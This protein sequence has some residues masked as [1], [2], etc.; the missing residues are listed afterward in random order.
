M[1]TPVDIKLTEYDGQYD[2]SWTKDGDFEMT[3]TLETAVLMSING[4][5]R[6]KSY[7]VAEAS[8]RRGW[9]GNLVYDNPDIEDGCGVWLYQQRRLN[10]QTLNGVRDETEKGLLWMV[11]DG[12]AKTVETFTRPQDGKV[13]ISIKIKVTDTDYL[14]LS[15]TTD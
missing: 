10:T 6:A 9:I 7:E 14:A 5:R 8:Y 13:L 1:S 4:E 3:D 2:I 11:S 12:I 15:V